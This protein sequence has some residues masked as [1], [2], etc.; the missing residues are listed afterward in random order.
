MNIK[1]YKWK[2]LSYV[3]SMCTKRSEKNEKKFYK[4]GTCVGEV[5]LVPK[6]FTEVK[7]STVAWMKAHPLKDLRRQ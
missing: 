4:R 5:I 2:T 3:A 6:I 7:F 1:F